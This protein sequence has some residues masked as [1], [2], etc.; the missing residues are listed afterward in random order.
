MLQ[1]LPEFAEFLLNLTK[2]SRDFPKMQQ[3]WE[4]PK[5]A[6]SIFVL[7]M[8][9]FNFRFEK[10]VIVC[11]FH[12]HE[13]LIFHLIF[14]ELS[15]PRSPLLPAA[16]AAPRRSTPSVKRSTQCF[17]ARIILKRSLYQHKI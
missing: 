9:T 11:N 13:H 3:F 7:E 5:I 8:R 4:N 2:F 14:T 1:K 15:S 6:H 12:F 17:F 16:P 10:H